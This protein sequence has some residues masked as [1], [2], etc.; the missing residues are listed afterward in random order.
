MMDAPDVDNVLVADDDPNVSRF[1][2]ALLARRGLK[3]HLARDATEALRQLRARPF[4]LIF[5]DLKMP[6][7]GG[8]AVLQGV[9]EV[10]PEAPVVMISGYGDV[11]TA[12][13]AMR[14]GCDDFLVKPLSPRHVESLL[15]TYLPNHPLPEA[16]S[17]ADRLRRTDCIV[18]KSRSLTRVLDVARRAA[19]T[20]VPVLVEG[21][22]GT[23][24]ELVARLV[25]RL[26]ARARG[27]FVRVNCA[28]LSE[29]LLESE[30]FGHE[31]GAFTGAS[32][33]RKGRFE[34]AHCG[35]LLL[36]E[37]TE[38]SVR[39]QAELLRVLEQQDVERLGGSE[40]IRVN[41]RVVSTTNRD[42][43]R[44]VRRGR[45]RADLFYRLSG[46]R[47][48]I[49]PLRE[50][51]EDVP[52]LV[53]HFVNQYAREAHRRIRTLD[54]DMLARFQ[55]FAWP[56]NV[57]QLR[58]AIR[59]ALILGEGPT[60]VLPSRDILSEGETVVE[61]AADLATL[62]RRHILEML[63]RTGGRRAE[64]SR[65]L[66]ISDRTLRT[67]LQKYRREG[68]IPEELEVG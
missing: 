68:L 4:A 45:F 3:G 37:I 59:T 6:G 31:R 29:S 41:V 8:F 61:D 18:G 32:G 9:K 13:R 55:T 12:V 16:T 17:E 34:R 44:E 20:A 58:N 23:G 47:I 40:P 54:Q 25:H 28:A 36:D 11:A 67:R 39:F 2:L 53:R 22:S 14:L 64:A 1:M 60:L 57:R 15:E 43:R 33:L 24:K 65:R 19:P 50:R 49:P 51:P 30:L 62:E 26:S 21:E 52:A 66:G 46:V 63:A 27:P 5:T 42:L 56:G 10:A 38:T 35:T 48:T 7:G